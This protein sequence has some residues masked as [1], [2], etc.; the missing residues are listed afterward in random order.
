M[1]AYIIKTFTE[2]GLPKTDIKAET[3][4]T[5]FRAFSNYV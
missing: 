1:I 5:I 4:N 2:K 3:E